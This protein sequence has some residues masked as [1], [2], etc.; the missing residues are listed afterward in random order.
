MFPNILFGDPAP[1]ETRGPSAGRLKADEDEVG[2]AAAEVPRPRL[3]NWLM[4][5]SEGRIPVAAAA[6][7]AAAAWATKFGGSACLGV[8][9]TG[10]PTDGNWLEPETEGGGG[11][12]AT[13]GLNCGGGGCCCCCCCEG[14]GI[15]GAPGAPNCLFLANTGCAWLTMIPMASLISGWS[16]ICAAA[17]CRHTS[18]T[19]RMSMGSMAADLAKCFSFN[20]P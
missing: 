6:A 18:M 5:G 20:R 1:D 3:P 11:W 19:G 15:G 12:L 14:G 17:C 4:K 2:A 8:G 10:P 7:A 13:V 16:A 9:L